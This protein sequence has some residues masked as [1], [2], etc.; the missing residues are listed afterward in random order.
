MTPDVC[1]GPNSP[2]SPLLLAAV[3]GSCPEGRAT[4][5]RCASDAHHARRGAPATIMTAPIVPAPRSA[6]SPVSA[7]GDHGRAGSG[8]HPLIAARAGQARRG[9]P[10]ARLC[11]ARRVNR[12]LALPLGASGDPVPPCR[13][14][15]HAP[16]GIARITRCE[17][18]GCRRWG[19]LDG[20]GGEERAR[21]HGPTE[22]RGRTHDVCGH[23]HPSRPDGGGR[24]QVPA[25]RAGGGPAL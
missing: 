21:R 12:R 6:R 15:A 22:G 4:C 13:P 16:V 7:W 14:E 8:R 11:S 3:V 17:K 19:M 18:C 10:V 5:S 9:G 25:H 2:M 1:L 24:G 20:G 23:Q